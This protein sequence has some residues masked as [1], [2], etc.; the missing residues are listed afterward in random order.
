MFTLNSYN[1]FYK[2]EVRASNTI[3]FP[4]SGKAC[5]AATWERAFLHYAANIAI[6]GIFQKTKVLPFLSKSAQ[7]D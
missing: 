6:V 1:Y 5:L 7:A 4:S 3:A 2:K